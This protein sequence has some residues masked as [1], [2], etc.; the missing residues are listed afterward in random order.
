MLY[1]WLKNDMCV[2][3]Q[4]ITVFLNGMDNLLAHGKPDQTVAVLCPEYIYDFN[5]KG[6]LN[7]PEQNELNLKYVISSSFQ[8][9]NLW[10]PYLY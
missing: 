5:H 9:M 2:Y 3:C 1:F 6:L 7:P 8:K 4:R 10:M